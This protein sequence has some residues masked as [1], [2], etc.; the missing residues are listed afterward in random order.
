MCIE[1]ENYKQ[2]DLFN[3]FDYNQID[4]DAEELLN[5]LLNNQNTILSSTKEEYQ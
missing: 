5:T 3:Y 2:H 4:T 1:I